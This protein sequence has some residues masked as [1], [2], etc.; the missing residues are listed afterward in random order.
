MQKSSVLARIALAAS[1][2]LAVFFAWGQ[3]H[4]PTGPAPASIALL[5]PDDLPSNSHFVRL[6]QDSAQEEGVL[7][8]P[9]KV[10]D[11]LTAITLGRASWEGVIVPDTFHRRMDDSVAALLHTY[12]ASGGRLMLVYDGGLLT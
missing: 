12:V 6:W 7:L 8:E 1:F 10:S 4:G 11:W 9:V 5:L 3:W 2:F